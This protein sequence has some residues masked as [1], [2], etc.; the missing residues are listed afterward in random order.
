MVAW[1]GGKGR[2]LAGGDGA[3]RGYSYRNLKQNE[4][5]NAEA[6]T[7]LTGMMGLAGFGVL[8]QS[9]S[10]AWRRQRWPRK[11]IVTYRI[12]GRRLGIY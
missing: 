9:E 6:R 1:R 11:E 10:G 2:R 5:K 4:E 3:D 12:K 8:R 7:E